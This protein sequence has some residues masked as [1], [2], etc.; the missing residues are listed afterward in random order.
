MAGGVEGRGWGVCRGTGNQLFQFLFCLG[1]GFVT[2]AAIQSSLEPWRLRQGHGLPLWPWN[3]G[4][5]LAVSDCVG[6]R[7]T[8]GWAFVG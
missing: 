3:N 1:T 6:S 2:A 7:L 8:S 5:C 4:A